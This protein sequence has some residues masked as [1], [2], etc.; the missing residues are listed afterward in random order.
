MTTEVPQADDGRRPVSPVRWVDA[1]C[2][3]FEAAWRAGAAPRIEDYLAETRQADRPALLGELVTLERELRLQRGE[4]P[5]V[6]EYLDRFPQH[7]G[8]IRATFGAATDPC[9]GPTA[10]PRPDT[11]RHLLFGILAL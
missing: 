5:G 11:G 4:R 2:D 1:A 6:E 7:A 3:R 9:G 8:V 10:R